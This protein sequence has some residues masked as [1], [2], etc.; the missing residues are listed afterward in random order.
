[1]TSEPSLR[2]NEIFHSIQGESSWAG[3][4]CVFVRL[5]GCHLRCTYC[6]TEYA[7]HEGARRLVADVVADVLAHP[8][9]LVEI[10]GGEPLL[11]RAVHDLVRALADAGRT[12]LI[13]TSGACDI[14]TCDPRAIRI[15]DLK[16]PGSGEVDRNLLENLEHL[17][18]RD[19]VKFV[20]TDRADYEWARSMIRTHRLPERCRDV[21]LSP[22]FEQ[23]AGLEILGAGGLP[24]RD[25]A[26]WILEDGLAVRLQTQ[27]HKWIWDPQ[28]RGV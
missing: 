7:F 20:I 6:D 5:T 4:P 23:A 1:M 15:L 21:L 8:A 2:I 27:L 26:E 18:D 3:C 13:E 28:T 22:V 17:T 9:T 16:T 19:E 14:S 12:V 24:L 25:L 11:Q 10:T